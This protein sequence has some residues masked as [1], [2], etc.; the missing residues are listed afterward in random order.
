[1]GHLVTVETHSLAF[2]CRG[3]GQ[4]A[5]AIYTFSTMY[6]P[7]AVMGL[8]MCKCKS[9][10]I[11]LQLQTYTSVCYQWKQ[12]FRSWLWN[13]NTLAENSDKTNLSR[14]NIFFRNHSV[15]PHRSYLRLDQKMSCCYMYK[16]LPR[17]TRS[18]SGH[19]VKQH[20]GPS[21]FYVTTVN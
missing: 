20:T 4:N 15:I 1:M 21:L 12:L 18:P 5:Q 6:P 2:Q 17:S 14:R 11:F 8:Y 19:S 16:G 10:P 9:A 7:I 13:G 3:L